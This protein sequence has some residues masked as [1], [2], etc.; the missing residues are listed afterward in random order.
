MISYSIC[1]DF[2]HAVTKKKLSSPQQ[3]QPNNMSRRFLRWAIPLGV[4]GAA[5]AAFAVPALFAV[6]HTRPA[7]HVRD[8]PAVRQR[9]EALEWFAMDSSNSGS[10]PPSPRGVSASVAP[11]RGRTPPSSTALLAAEPAAW[12]N[13]HSRTMFTDCIEMVVPLKRGL[14]AAP[15]E[16]QLEA[17]MQSFAEGPLF[18]L[19]LFILS[20]WLGVATRWRGG[21]GAS[22][23]PAALKA[24]DKFGIWSVMPT[25]SF[26]ET[27]VAAP[28]GDVPTSSVVAQ[29]EAVWDGRINN[30]TRFL[31]HGKPIDPAKDVVEYCGMYFKLVQP[32][33]ATTRATCCVVQWGTVMHVN[34]DNMSAAMR[35]LW[36]VM[37]VGH[38]FYAL[39]L[40]KSAA[41]TMMTKSSV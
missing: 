28:G 14:Q 26:M 16:A 20:K 21:D 30:A 22:A 38:D 7:F 40:A 4:V 35:W 1:S 34:T 32:A 3:Q 17:F 13:A 24:G 23:P 8:H 19:E 27:N 11:T 2:I 5:G 36:P 39:M 12:F 33:S 37:C 9:L 29:C 10:P 18:R 41:V 31:S 6:S 25:T 15:P